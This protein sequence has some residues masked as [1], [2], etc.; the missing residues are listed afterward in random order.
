MKDEECKIRVDYTIERGGNG[1]E[2]CEVPGLVINEPL[3]FVVIVR[4]YE[5]YDFQEM[6]RSL[7]EYYNYH[8]AEVIP[9]DILESKYSMY[10]F[11]ESIIN[12][13]P[14]G[15]E[16]GHQINVL[17]S[18]SEVCDVIRDAEGGTI[19]PLSDEYVDYNMLYSE[20]CIH[21]SNDSGRI[22]AKD[23]SMNHHCVDDGKYVEWELIFNRGNQEDIFIRFCVLLHE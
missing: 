6:E 9:V 4:N 7:N 18:F 20:N 3:A 19:D 17:E 22:F 8:E 16:T 13:Y 23:I 11:K 10:L 12:N 14:L 5:D 21:A 2:I 1:G 15:P